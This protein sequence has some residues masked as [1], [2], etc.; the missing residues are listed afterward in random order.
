MDWSPLQEDGG[1]V[2]LEASRKSPSLPRENPAHQASLQHRGLKLPERRLH[3][4]ASHPPRNRL[5]DPAQHGRESPTQRERFHLHVHAAV[6]LD[7]QR[8]GI[9]PPQVA[10]VA[11]R[12]QQPLGMGSGILDLADLFER[13][14]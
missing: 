5:D 7:E 3:A 10:A 6:V 9:S 13:R 11:A 2:R 8:E 14:D 1:I 12:R 4:P